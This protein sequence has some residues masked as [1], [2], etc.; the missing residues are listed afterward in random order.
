MPGIEYAHS[1]NGAYATSAKMAAS[2]DRAPL[3]FRGRTAEEPG[4][5]DRVLET[6]LHI[7]KL[8]ISFAVSRYRRVQRGGGYPAPPQ[9]SGHLPDA[10]ARDQT[11]ASVK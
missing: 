8:P 2:H 11:A 10:P 3:T 6:A 4:D 9:G 7:N 5:A 1:M